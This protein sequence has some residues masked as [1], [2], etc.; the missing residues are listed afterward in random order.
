MQLDLI[1]PEGEE[2][3]LEFAFRADREYPDQDG[4]LGTSVLVVEFRDGR[5][6]E[7]PDGWLID[8]VGPDVEERLAQRQQ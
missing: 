7:Y 5:K 1:G 6:E 3:T 8:S 2:K 4:A